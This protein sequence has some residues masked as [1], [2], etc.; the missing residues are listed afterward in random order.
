[1]LNIVAQITAKADYRQEIVAALR[2]LAEGSL[3]E[4]GNVAY[5]ICEDT[6]KPLCF[7][8]IEQWRDQDAIDFHNASP[9]FQAFVAAIDGKVDG[10]DIAVLKPL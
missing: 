4:E 3:A 1:M 5:S 9:H 10:L 7:A 6:Q 8:V 2:L